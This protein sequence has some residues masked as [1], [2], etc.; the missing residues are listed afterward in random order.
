MTEL[1]ISEPFYAPSTE[2]ALDHLFSS[3]DGVKKKIEDIAGFM[4]GPARLALNYCIEG[5]KH[6]RERYG[7][8]MDDLLDVSRAVKALDADYWNRAMDLTDVRECMPQARR[9]E[10]H[11]LISKHATP[12]FVPENVIPTFQ[13]LLSSR[14]K[15]FAERVDGVFRALSR[16]HVTNQ[17]EGFGKRMILNYVLSEYGMGTN[18]EKVGYIHDLRCVIARF[19]GRDEPEYNLSDRI[20][21]TAAEDPGKW[22]TVD[23]GAL[24]LRVYAGVRTGHLEVHPDMAWR[25]NAV[26]ASLYPAAIPSQFREPPKRKVRDFALM[27]KPLPFAVLSLLRGLHGSKENDRYL[28]LGYTDNPDKSQRKRLGEVLAAIGGVESGDGWAFDYG[29]Q[30]VINQIICSGCIP[31]QQSHQ[32][33]PTPES[34]AQDAVS[35]AMAGH[36][37]GMRWLE[38]SAG[39]GN[40]ASLFPTDAAVTCYD[41]S[42]L[43]VAVLSARGLLA[44][45]HDFL[46]TSVTERYD[47]IVMNPPYSEGRWR[48]HVEH[49]ASK[50]LPGGR[51]VAILP[52]SARGKRLLPGWSET[53]GN[54]Y[55]NAFDGAS[56]SVVIYVGIKP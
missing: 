10:W 12:E 4:D 36:T 30:G 14:S 29:P 56:V 35:E 34:I 20:V 19:M 43:H 15:F 6:E 44:I 51:L 23:G 31:D 49:A 22:I 9:S 5:A 16:S 41:I 33:Y 45:E 21:R 39:T 54:A 24:R 27:Q 8:S 40:L 11:E 3:R 55:D 42:A 26:L 2:G 32:F 1:Q 18:Y 48:A 13:D 7:L 37:P 53:W 52:A 47:R 38:P 28:A 50:L 25:L 17:P 46:K